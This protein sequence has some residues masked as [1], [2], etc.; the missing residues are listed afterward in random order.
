MRL[1]CCLRG[2]LLVVKSRV[3]EC[4][5][6]GEKIRDLWDTAMATA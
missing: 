3:K 5:T 2:L 1:F 6:D 4:W